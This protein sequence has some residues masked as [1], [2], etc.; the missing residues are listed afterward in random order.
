LELTFILF[1]AVVV[2]SA[3]FHYLSV[4]FGV[5]YGTAVTPVLL[6]MGFLPLQ[7]VPAVLLAQL[8]GGL[9]GSVAHHQLGNMKLHTEIGGT[10]DGRRFD[11]RDL[12]RSTDFRVVAILVA[13]GALGVLAG[14]VVA[15]S[16]PV[17]VVEIYIG[18]LVLG[19]GVN[20]LLFG[21]HDRKFSWT[22]LTAFGLLGAFNK[23]VSGGGY[24]PLIAG[25]QMLS[26]REARSAVASTTLAV[27]LVC[28]MG[29]LSY[30]VI[31]QG[32]IYWRLAVAAL[33]GSVVS[34]PFAALTVRKMKRQR[35]NLVIGAGTA[36]LGLALLV[37]ALV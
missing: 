2:V 4:S 17:I 33:I 9:V 5:G 16:I 36:I 14:A 8:G 25:G 23:G 19:I 18:I 26:G 3:S 32:D 15:V 37:R 11:V 1:L 34:A 6:L 21:T 27:S 28:L 24:V 12:L 29:F 13:C 10:L 7:A 22:R 30:L 35:L 20:V 31:Q